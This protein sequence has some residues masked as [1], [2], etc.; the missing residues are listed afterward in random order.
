MFEYSPES[1]ERLINKLWVDKI[2]SKE[3]LID[4]NNSKLKDKTNKFSKMYPRPLGG[5]VLE[6]GFK[7]GH[8]IYALE[9]NYPAIFQID[10]FD[11]NPGLE[12]IIPFIKEINNKVGHLLIESVEQLSFAD[13][14]FDF[15]NCCD[16]FEHLPSKVQKKGLE[17]IARVMKPTAILGVFSPTV[18]DKSVPQHIKL[19]S[20]K[21]ICD[22]IVQAGFKKLSQHTF[23]RG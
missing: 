6:C 15:V 14:T 1:Y 21:K 17:E 3:D 18:V 7:L 13:E 9:Q 12:K 10:G 2:N 19:T 23:T 22:E 16:F 5:R 4:L 11:F 20:Q 8:S